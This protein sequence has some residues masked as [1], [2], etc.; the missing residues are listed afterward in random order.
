MAAR[1][2]GAAVGV[3]L[4]AALLAAGCAKKGPPS[5]GPPDLA[6]PRVVST[7]P[8]SGAAAVAL[9]APL[10]LTF[11]EGMEPRSTVEAISIA[12]RVEIRR[13]RWSG[14]T[15]TLELAERLERGQTYTLFL[16]EGARD[17]HGNGLVGGAAVVFSTADTFPSGRIEGKVEARGFGGTGTALWCYDAATGRVPDSTARD[18]DA[19]GLADADSRFRI[20]GLRVPGRYRIWA[21]ADLNGNHSFE[22]ASDVLAPADTVFEL[23]AARPVV[24]PVLLRVTNPRAPGLLAGAVLDTLRDSLGVVRVLAV[25]DSDTTQRVIRDADARGGFQLSL[26]AG[27]WTIRAFRDFDRNRVW[28]PQREPASEPLR[29]FVEPAADEKNLTLVLRRRGGVP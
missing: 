12:P 20:D 4:F 29:F 17:N 24:G 8:D 27:R 19:I 5:G 14:R 3:A 23:T 26:A 7:Q 21:F 18:F 22:P 28:D 25:A 15:L 10:S 6:P 9:D 16:T 2:L 13:R 11:S 1:G